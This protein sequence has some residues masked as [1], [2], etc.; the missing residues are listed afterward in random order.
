MW[1]RY[2]MR[3]HC[4]YWPVLAAVC[5]LLACEAQRA[6]LGPAGGAQIWSDLTWRCWSAEGAQVL[7][8]PCADTQAQRFEV[9]PAGGAADVRLVAGDGRCVTGSA[10]GGAQA[11]V[12]AACSDS[13]TQ[14]I[15][16]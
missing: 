16:R 7:E 10:A 3:I 4:G 8:R 11:L 12:L 5:L 15:R 2:H 14:I 1:Y 13:A 9:E 6:G